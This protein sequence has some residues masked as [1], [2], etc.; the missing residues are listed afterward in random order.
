MAA[1]T[2]GGMNTEATPWLVVGVAGIACGV[3]AG[4]QHH[5]TLGS[6]AAIGAIAM[7]ATGLVSWIL[8]RHADHAP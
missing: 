2:T 1:A 6:V 5:V 4:V 3:I 7:A 8:P